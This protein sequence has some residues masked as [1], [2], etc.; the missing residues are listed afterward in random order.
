[1]DEGASGVIRFKKGIKPHEPEPL[2][3]PPESS[4]YGKGGWHECRAR[5]GS[6][7]H[8]NAVNINDRV[9]GV[10]G[11]DCSGCSQS[12]YSKEFPNRTDD[13]VKIGAARTNPEGNPMRKW[14]IAFGV[15]LLMAVAA[16]VL[17]KD[18]LN[19]NIIRLKSGRIIPV[20][21]TWESGA[22]LFYENDKEIHF[23]SLAD[24]QSIEKQSISLL[25]STT[26]TRFTAF[27]EEC[28]KAVN[29]LLQGGLELTRHSRPTRWLIIGSMAAPGPLILIWRLAR[30]R[31]KKKK[32]VRPSAAAKETGQEMPGRADV[33]RFFLNLFRQQ[34][35][36]E[37]EMPTEF[38]QL[39]SMSSGSRQIYE[40]RV[41]NGGEWVKRR[42]TLGPL[43]EDSGS[44]SKCFYVIFDQHLVVKIPPKPIKDFDDYVASIKKE[45]HIVER[46]AP[47]ECIIPRV[48]VILSQVHQL[49]SLPDTSSDVLE[50]KYI[51]WLRSNPSYQ[52]YLKIKGTFAFFMDLS[53]YYF[54]GH[55]IDGLHDLTDP[56]RSE[57]GSTVDLIRYPAK[58]KERYGEEN[59]SVGFEIRDLYHQCEA[60]V[61]HLLKSR[62]KAAAVTPYRIQVWFLNYLEK[63]DICESDPAIPSEM[64]SGLTAVF[65]RLFDKY[66][67]S[68]EAY[69]S[70]IRAF[71]GR[72]CLEQN[73]QILSGMLTNLLD[74]LAWLSE[75]K[76]AMRDLKPDNLLVAGDPQRFPAFLRS[77]ADYS[78]GFIDVETA[79]YLGASFD[80]D[81]KQPLLGGTPY[82]A[83]PSHLFPN[84]A[85][86]ACLGDIAWI[87]RLQDWQAVLVMI[88]KTVTG[89]LLFEHT[90]KRFVDIKARVAAALQR[91]EPLESQMEDASRT[92]WRSAVAEFRAKMKARESALRFVEV[93][94]PEAAKTMFAQALRRD[95][96]CIHGSIQNLVDTQSHF[97]SSGSR[98]QLLESSH[99]RIG[100]I[101][102]TMQAKMP[103]AKSDSFQ[104]TLRFLQHLSALKALV[105]RKSQM[106]DVLERT[107][108]PRLNAYELILLMFNCVLTSMHRK[109]WSALVEEDLRL[110]CSSN[111]ELSLATTI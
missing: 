54:L 49:S 82:Y 98:R 37:P 31:A 105:E 17:A 45:R 83:T 44:K 39:P 108:A 57:I 42:M 73:R 13:K 102:R 8:F 63:R 33:V 16:A 97:T 52:D 15:L 18:Q 32:S 77:A 26:C 101:L 94:I 2:T 47:K 23:V 89:E 103:P 69:L 91:R 104:A 28:L 6:L 62:G 35:G 95:I 66:R 72:L 46:L 110:S 22:D 100:Q 84:T 3:Q 75:K 27:V 74:L 40:L 68:V 86:R 56:I 109:D 4:F 60:E 36:I 70:G 93:V 7:I 96:D 85:L 38:V 9:K 10:N 20:D 34:L 19:R 64:T 41:K 90:A 111:D 5:N 30:N 55:I 67:R 21:R 59:E 48:S 80:V 43:G 71:A 76:V 11:R 53:R 99:C 61:R 24:I 87:L 29:P 88:F 78:L 79:V 50:E 25:A 106:I 107:A 58:F 12:T 81:I 51:D 65:A 92:F 14:K 1:L